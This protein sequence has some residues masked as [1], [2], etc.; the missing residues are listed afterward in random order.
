MTV[1]RPPIGPWRTAWR[2]LQRDRWSMAALLIV[3]AF[4]VA[5]FSGGAI[6][7]RAVGHD[8]VA[9][10]PYA[11]PGGIKPVGPFTSVYAISNAPVDDYG[12]IQAPPK[13]TKKGLFLLGADGPLGRDEAIRLLDGMRTSL[14]VAIIAALIS[15]IVALPLGCASGY[16]GGKFD[17]L[18]SQF[19]ETLMAFPLL[20]FLVFASAKL[21][22]TFRQI[23]WS[24]VVPAGV[25][26]EALLIGLF[27][28]FYPLRLI[29][30][31]MRRLRHA[32]FVESA[33]MVGASHTRIV[34]RHL[35][36]HVMPTV[37][38]WA[39]IAVGTNI[40]LEVGLS[41]IGLGVQ[42]STATLG[43][44]LSETWGTVYAPHVYDHR[45]YTPWQTIFPTAVI[46][47]T[48]VSLNQLAEGV[49]RA[50]SPWSRA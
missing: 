12:Q 31:D 32:E 19:T 25:L 3:C 27:T 11:A 44:M 38:V 34:T 30:N 23:G 28:A 8:G 4:V 49:Q 6:L 17:G 18:V 5:A 41:F 40:L 14:E 43:S 7:T 39:A 2:R 24:W 48:V 26:G 50:I 46:L 36:A 47:L 22:P 45:L 15:L 9:P 20:F 35:L 42:P 29:R 37:L 21:A 16:V 13:G 1:E 33:E 10:F